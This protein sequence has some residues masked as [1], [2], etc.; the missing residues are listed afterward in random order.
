MKAR[1]HKGPNSAIRSKANESDAE[2][3]A[4]AVVDASI[5]EGKQIPGTNLWTLSSV[6][7]VLANFVPLAGAVFFKWSV[8]GILFSFWM[9]NVAIGVFNILKMAASKAGAFNLISKFFLIPFFAFHYGM[10][11]FVH[12]MFIC[13]M[14][15]NGQYFSSQQAA[16]ESDPAVPSSWVAWVFGTMV[17]PNMVPSGLLWAPLALAISHAVSF[18][19][20]FLRKGEYRQI[21]AGELMTRPYGRVVIMHITIL[22]GGFL[23]VATGS[24]QPAVAVLV[25][26]KIAVD[27][28]SHKWE[29]KKLAK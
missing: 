25:L 28:L 15:G 17:D 11:C 23:V 19:S 27:F 22:A 5:D 7:L 13:A 18:Y 20:N 9:E 29:R 26:L 6:S 3:A 8:F 2:N 24:S 21:T 4:P 14:F 10:F 1:L 12:G 16:I